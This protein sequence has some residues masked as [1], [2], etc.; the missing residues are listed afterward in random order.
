MNKKK[1]TYSAQR[2]DLTEWMKK[3][4][5]M[6]FAAIREQHHTLYNQ[7]YMTN[8]VRLR[9][10]KCTK[11]GHTWDVANEGYHY[12]KK[13]ACPHC[14]TKETVNTTAI[15]VYMEPHDN[16]WY[17][18]LF[19]LKAHEPANNNPDD[20]FAWMNEERT[21]EMIPYYILRYEQ[22]NNMV[23]YHAHNQTTTW[24]M[25]STAVTKFYKRGSRDYNATIETIRRHFKTPLGQT[26]CDGFNDNVS[27]LLEEAITNVDNYIET[28][29]TSKAPTRT[30]VI[31]DMEAA[32]KPQIITSDFLRERT[33]TMNI[34]VVSDYGLNKKVAVMCT[35]CH[36]YSFFNVQRTQNIGQLLME[37]NMSV[38]PHCGKPVSHIP[39]SLYQVPTAA[40][41]AVVYE[42]TNLPD[43]QLLVRLFKVE[44]KID[45]LLDDDDKAVPTMAHKVVEQT[46]L[47]FGK[48]INKYVNN[49]GKWEKDAFRSL[50]HR[51]DS[52]TNIVAN[53]DEE[54]LDVINKTCVRY[55]GLKEAIGLDKRYKKIIDAGNMSYLIAWYHNPAIESIYKSQLYAL[56]AEIIQGYK[57]TDWTIQKKSNVYEA[58]ECSPRTLKIARAVNCGVRDF[59]SLKKYCENDPTIDADGYVQ[60]KEKVNIA[61]AATIAEY[62]IRWKEI[63]DY[64]E[65]VEAHQCIPPRETMTI[66]RD[67]LYMA[68]ELGYNLR[69]RSRRFPSSLKKEHDIVMY[70]QRTLSV[71][72]DAENFAANA[73]KNAERYEFSY[74]KLFAVVPKT[75]QDVVEEATSQHNCL[76]SYI[77]RITNGD[78]AVAFVRYKDTP[79]QSYVTVEIRGDR[80]MQVRGFSNSIP[81]TGEVIQF[82]QHWCKAKSLHLV[83]W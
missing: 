31:V 30:E 63:L 25:Y 10:Y 81:N 57:P 77:R 51:Y 72:I 1:M 75:T 60:L 20:V 37:N 56:A 40:H 54:L 9:K 82:L 44:S 67:Y 13:V 78:T 23:L 2:E 29:K 15:N 34:K 3:I 41:M 59:A 26:Q 66:W 45:V 76:S 16:G 53:T 17:M 58:L 42:A 7:H 49:N 48:K 27:T 18:M 68:H 6:D 33:I 70:A 69:E 83:N 11:C 21:W 32:Y 71:Q 14:M 47:F 55:S 80:I 46:R 65:I 28:K 64:I 50:D 4:E 19:A 52:S 73:K 35:G 39:T 36:G 74:D 62:G 61:N 24:Y 79:T 22:D 12:S 8:G 43:E 5:T 38:C